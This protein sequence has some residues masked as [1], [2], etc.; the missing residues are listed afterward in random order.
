MLEEELP[1]MSVEDHSRG[2]ADH[3]DSVSLEIFLPR[4]QWAGSEDF[5]E[6]MGKDRLVREAVLRNVPLIGIPDASSRRTSDGIFVRVRCSKDDR[7]T[8]L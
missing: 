6:R 1:L 3:G 7:E 4:Q 8:E 2:Y 5:A